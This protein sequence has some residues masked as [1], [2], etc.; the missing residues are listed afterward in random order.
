M[1]KIFYSVLVCS[2]LIGAAAHANERINPEMMRGGIANGS[3]TPP[4]MGGER[5]WRGRI[6][7]LP[8]MGSDTPPMMEFSTT[9]C[10][11]FTRG[12][13][14]GLRG[15]DVKELQEMLHENGFLDAS[16]TGFFGKKT[17]EAVIRFQKDGGLNP[18]GF[19]GEL[20]RKHHEKHCGDGKEG[21]NDQH[22]F[23]STTPPMM[24]DDHRG[25]G[26]GLSNPQASGTPSMIERYRDG[27]GWKGTSTPPI[28]P[29]ASTTPTN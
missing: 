13:A 12:L 15:D 10:R 20:S 9:S 6:G 27:H 19:F 22:G 5:G 23:G 17:K 26:R 11:K 24:G 25:E 18:S 28:I 21:R 29:P 4:M 2:L 16:S 3:G 1:K 14:F 7:T 8:M